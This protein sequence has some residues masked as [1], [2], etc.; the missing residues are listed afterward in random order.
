MFAIQRI[1]VDSAIIFIFSA[2]KEFFRRPLNNGGAIWWNQQ[3]IH[4]EITPAIERDAKTQS[5]RLPINLRS[6]N[7][8]NK[9]AILFTL[10]FLC[11]KSV[12]CGW[13]FCVPARM[14]FNVWCSECRLG[15]DWGLTGS[16]IVSCTFNWI[17]PESRN[18]LPFK[19]H[20]C[21]PNCRNAF[22]SAVI[23]YKIFYWFRNA[24]QYN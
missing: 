1:V 21:N 15:I 14:S 24:N 16:N 13:G 3:I 10:R 17:D 6:R 7:R 5:P 18:T 23:K 22:W 12:E 4:N 9:I 2:R 20:S 8:T 19:I 11:H